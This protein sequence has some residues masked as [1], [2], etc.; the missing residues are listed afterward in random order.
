MIY[1]RIERA[2][3]VDEHRWEIVQLMIYYRIESTS[4]MSHHMSH[5]MFDDLL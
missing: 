2:G 3:V 1:Y 4:N 5:L